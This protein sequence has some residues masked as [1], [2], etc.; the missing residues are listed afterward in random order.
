MKK[1]KLVKVYG[2]P[3]CDTVKKAISFLKE[4]GVEFSF[5]DYKKEG[6]TI[7]KL[8]EWIRQASVEK[9]AN[10]NSTTWKN[11]TEEEKL[12]AADEAGLIH[13]LQEN[14]SMIKR[15]IIEANSKLILIGY[16]KEL[17][18]EILLK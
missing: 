6:I 14:T 13:L 8:Q 1:R 5:H 17:Y 10:K 16:N 7:T 18:K 3:N 15:P 9:I 2:I 12:S 4:N 11:L